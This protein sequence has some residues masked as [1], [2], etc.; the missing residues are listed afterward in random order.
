MNICFKSIWV[1]R[2]AVITCISRGGKK[3]FL[4][5]KIFIHMGGGVYRING[6]RELFPFEFQ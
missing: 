6:G 5:K 4:W 2:L 3:N 1:N